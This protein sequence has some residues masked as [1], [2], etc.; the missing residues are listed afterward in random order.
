[1]T[2]GYSGDVTFVNAGTLG[3]VP[4]KRDDLIAH[5][6]SRSDLLREIGCLAYEVG[7][8]EEHPDTVFVVELWESAQA[9]Q[10]SLTLPAVRASIAT[11]RPLLSGEFGGFRFEVVGSPLR[12]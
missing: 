8:N 4:G 5:L 1:M 10:A 7:T 12:D 6:T 11:A 3:A 9:H 2:D